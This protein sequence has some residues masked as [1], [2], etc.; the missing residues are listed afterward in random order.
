MNIFIFKSEE[1][2]KKYVEN[3]W[4]YLKS[5]IT[6]LTT[7]FQR[8]DNYF[9]ILKKNID[10]KN[11]IVIEN[12][13]NEKKINNKLPQKSTSKKLVHKRSLS[14]DEIGG[15]LMNK[16]NDGFHIKRLPH[17][18]KTNVKKYSKDDYETLFEK[19]NEEDIDINSNSKLSFQNEKKLEIFEVNFFFSLYF[20]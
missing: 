8:I 11:K 14:N 18:K 13:L 3:E 9:E 10:N 7:D 2:Q 5:L 12:S 17:F 19:Y 20:F 15:I 6:G 4:N 16:N 1:I